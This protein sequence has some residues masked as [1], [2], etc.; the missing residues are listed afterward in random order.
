MLLCG[1]QLETIG[2]MSDSRKCGPE[3]DPE[4]AR[5]SIAR[6][7][8]IYRNISEVADKSAKT[9]CPYKDARSRCSA[10]FGCKNQRFIEDKPN[11]PAVCTG[12]DKLDYRF[13]W[14]QE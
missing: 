8:D 1:F 9:R 6:L 10:K 2:T 11:E 13:A 12:S 5:N 14:E 4:A 3:A 7:M